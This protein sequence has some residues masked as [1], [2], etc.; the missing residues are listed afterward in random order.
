MTA[1]PIRGRALQALRAAA[2]HPR[3]LRLSAHPSAMPALIELGYVVERQARWDGA[4]PGDMAHFITPAG[5]ELL[6][7]LGAEELE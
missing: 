4:K 5:Q 7:A 2:L 3:G 6:K 1:P